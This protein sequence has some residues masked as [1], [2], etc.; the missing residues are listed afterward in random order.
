MEFNVNLAIVIAPSIYKVDAQNLPA[1]EHD[2]S[3]IDALLTE[4]GKFSD[5]LILKGE[6]TA[7][8]TKTKLTDF[9]KK[10]SA[11][12]IEE[13]F[14]YY[15]GHGD[16]DGNEFYYI[17]SDYQSAK[18]NQTSLQNEE[19][20]GLI[21]S[22]RPNLTVKI[23]D[24]CQSGVRYIKDAGSFG[25]FLKRTQ[26]GR[27][28]KFYFFA[29]SLEDQ[30]SY[31]DRDLSYFTREFVE[32]V[33][34]HGSQRVRY[35]DIIDYLVDVSRLS[36][37]Q[38]PFFVVQ[39]DMTAIFCEVT[40]KL[41]ANIRA[42][43]SN[44]SQ[45][46]PSAS[47]VSQT[48]PSERKLVSIIKRD[49]ERY[50]SE[51]EAA[52]ALSSFAAELPAGTKPLDLESLFDVSCEQDST[53]EPT[54][55]AAKIGRHIEKNRGEYFA[56]AVYE[57]ENYDQEIEDWS[58]ISAFTFMGRPNYRTV[59]RQR[60]VVTGFQSTTPLPYK[61]LRLIAIPRFPNLP[62]CVAYVVPILSKTD[63]R[64]YFAIGTYRNTGWKDEQL[65]DPLEWKI[66][67]FAIKNDSER[68]NAVQIISES[69]YIRCNAEV[70][71]RFANAFDEGDKPQ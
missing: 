42:I 49:A 64:L 11:D 68:Q 40:D 56:E 8:D 20:D 70:K 57:Y 32:A 23:V 41:R 37:R 52:S 47:I 13:L 15:S 69:L 43:L 31:Q 53:N 30:S 50:A 62:R 61:Q 46:N 6:L 28:N 39:D 18:R 44:T 7:A 21:K 58:G 4:T 10:H 54:P 22:I 27:F 59:T 36:A 33:I 71:R 24:A 14:F 1:C 16:F 66:F 34:E 9:V 29:S 63:V 19:L 45:S 17:L 2:A 3:V 38:S 26:D 12:T 55:D 35:K 67:S 51:K 65:A 60:S 5:L 25:E 48:E